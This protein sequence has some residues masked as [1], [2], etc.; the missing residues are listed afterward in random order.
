LRK[1]SRM[2]RPWSVAGTNW[3]FFCKQSDKVLCNLWKRAVVFFFV[4]FLFFFFFFFFLFEIN[5]VGRR[6]AA[7]TARLAPARRC[8]VFEQTELARALGEA[9][10]T[11]NSDRECD[12]RCRSHS[13]TPHANHHRGKLDAK[14]ARTTKGASYQ[15]AL[16]ADPNHLTRS[17]GSITDTLFMCA[18]TAS[19]AWHALR[20]YRG[21]SAIIPPLT[22]AQ[23][24]G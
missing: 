2:R 1:L 14:S 24:R 10:G 21:G 22:G 20:K 18:G 11:R 17:A 4:C 3:P 23:F 8:G 15:G 9:S 13:T 16:S 19:P 12:Q 7:S 5:S 6:A